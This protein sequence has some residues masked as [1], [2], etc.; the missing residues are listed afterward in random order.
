[1][2]S[3]VAAAEMTTFTWSLPTTPGL[4][5]SGRGHK[6][7]VVAVA[8]AVVAVVEVVVAVVA[9]GGRA[10]PSRLAF[11]GSTARR[12]FGLATPVRCGVSR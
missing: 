6:P 11:Q 8:V 4:Y 1:M 5:A 9:V 12:D 2:S 7:R 3:T 10:D